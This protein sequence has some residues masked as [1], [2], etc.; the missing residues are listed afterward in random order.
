MFWDRLNRDVMDLI[1]TYVIGGRLCDV[2]DTGSLRL[3][4]KEMN[5]MLTESKSIDIRYYWWRQLRRTAHRVYHVYQ[6]KPT[7]ASRYHLT[8]CFPNMAFVEF[9]K[10][11]MASP[12][13]RTWE[14]V[15]SM[16]RERYGECSHPLHEGR[17]SCDTSWSPEEDRNPYHEWRVLAYKRFGRKWTK[18]KE[19]M[20]D[21]LQ[22]RVSALQQEKVQ[23][24]VLANTYEPMMKR[25]NTRIQNKHNRFSILSV[26]NIKHTIQE[27]L[28]HHSDTLSRHQKQFLTKSLSLER[29]HS[30]HVRTIY[31]IRSSL[32]LVPYRKPS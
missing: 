12:E 20:L 23:H 6:V 4:G 9:H 29:F 31:S 1:L 18:A 8:Q 3:S 14:E 7:F 28:Q 2:R 27:L 26:E 16:I 24:L 13:K 15:L 5:R 32:P 25:E 10:E 11:L 19:T 17:Y 22:K 30:S 21:M